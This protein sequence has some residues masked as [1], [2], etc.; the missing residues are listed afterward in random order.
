MVLIGCGEGTGESVW[1]NSQRM[2]MRCPSCVR[3]WRTC[4]RG[5][6]REREREFVNGRV[7]T[8]DWTKAVIKLH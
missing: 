1:T 8:W 3:K 4:P 5:M 7:W 2:C 6:A